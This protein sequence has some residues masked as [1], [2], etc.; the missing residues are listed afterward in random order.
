[1]KTEI[2]SLVWVSTFT[3]VLWIPYVLNRI[4][5]RGIVSTVG[6]PVDP[7]PLAPWAQRLRAA[8]ANAVENLVVFAVLMLASTFARLYSSTFWAL[9]DTRTPLR[10][11]VVRVALSD[12]KNIM[13]A[14]KAVDE[15][16]NVIQEN[17][18]GAP[19]FGNPVLLPGVHGQT[20]TAFDEFA[21]GELMGQGQSGETQTHSGGFLERDADLQRHVLREKGIVLFGPPAHTLVEPV[22]PDT[23]RRAAEAVRWERAR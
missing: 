23:L 10:F 16:N 12:N 9:R 4:M 8:H 22:D 20:G 18:A 11:A 1:M 19:F 5:V 6:Y 3:A 15:L 14:R 7:P 21:A 13:K 2:A 17:L